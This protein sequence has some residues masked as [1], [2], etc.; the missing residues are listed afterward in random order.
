MAS[1]YHL[2]WSVVERKYVYHDLEKIV[3][4]II[5]LV[6]STSQSCLESAWIVQG[7]PTGSII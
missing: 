1:N 2:I 7:K 6:A 3:R 4:R 5:C